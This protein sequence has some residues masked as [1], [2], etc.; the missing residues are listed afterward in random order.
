LIN[1]D[2]GFRKFWWI[3]W[4]SIFR[5]TVHSVHVH[6]SV[7]VLVHLLIYCNDLSSA[8]YFSGFI[9]YNN[10]NQQCIDRFDWSHHRHH[11]PSL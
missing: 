11:R 8:M 2:T 6:I 7:K 3:S 1:I 10:Y 9:G 4:I 5:P